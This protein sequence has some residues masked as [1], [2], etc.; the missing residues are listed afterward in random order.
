MPPA[1]QLRVLGLL[2]AG[3]LA[4]ASLAL[5]SMRTTSAVYDETAHLP[6]GYTYLTL[7]DFR[8]NPEHPPLAKELAALPLLLLDLRMPNAS[9]PWALGQQWEFGHRFLYEWNDGDRVLFWGRLPM[10]ALGC[11]LGAAVLLMYWLI[12]Y[13]MY[14]RKLFLKV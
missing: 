9:P 2:A 5:T 6:A 13:W 10:V 7:R 1:R 14:R 12:L 8:M 11:V 3:I 4:Y